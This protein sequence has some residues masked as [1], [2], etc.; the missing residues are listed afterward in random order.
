MNNT[1]KTKNIIITIICHTSHIN[2]FF[3]EIGAVW[4]R[5]DAETVQHDQKYTFHK[6]PP[7]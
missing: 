3:Y 5:A 7:V 4:R 1:L 6:L 2:R